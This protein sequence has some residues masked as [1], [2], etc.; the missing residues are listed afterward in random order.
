MCFLSLTTRRAATWLFCL[1]ATARTLDV[2]YHVFILLASGAMGSVRGLG[3]DSGGETR[4]AMLL[5]DSA[6]VWRRVG[7]HLRGQEKSRARVGTR[8]WW[9]CF[10]PVLWSPVCL[11]YSGLPAF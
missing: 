5:G 6:G 7:E 1:R 3:L 10:A 9:C 11:L 2:R 8:A 4:V